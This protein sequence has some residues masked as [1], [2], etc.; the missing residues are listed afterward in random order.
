M[1]DKVDEIR[2]KVI[3]HEAQRYPTVGDW[4]L[5]PDNVSSNVTL[6]I[7]VSDMGDWRA[8]MAVAV[9][10]IV[11]ALSCIA[12][13]VDPKALDEFD[14]AYEMVRQDVLEGTKTW[15]AAEDFL[16]KEFG[17]H[18]EITE[19]SEPGDDLHSP[20]R[21]QHELGTQVEHILTEGLHLPWSLYESEIA[22][23][24]AE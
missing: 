17:G 14:S 21:H 15:T 8:N 3:P 10:E 20:Y 5:T 1:I 4:F 22:E 23:L 7:R 24:D 11:E 12:D 19:R 16:Q 6:D 2:V 9:H 13:E 18:D